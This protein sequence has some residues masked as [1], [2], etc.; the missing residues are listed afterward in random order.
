MFRLGSYPPYSSLYI[1]AYIY[2]QIFQTLKSQILRPQA[3][4]VRDILYKVHQQIKI[5]I[6]VINS[7]RL[8][9]NK[10]T[11]IADIQGQIYFI[12]CSFHFANIISP[13]LCSLELLIQFYKIILTNQKICL[14]KCF[15]ESTHNSTRRKFLWG[16]NIIL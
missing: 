12:Y 2:M 13:I 15:H 7:L 9:W 3:F 1:Y 11:Q 14:L 10:D 4:W 16:F 6:Q 5:K 8:Y